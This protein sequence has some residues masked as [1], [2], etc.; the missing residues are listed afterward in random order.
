MNV[1]EGIVYVRLSNGPYHASAANQKI[2][3]LLKCTK[4]SINNSFYYKTAKGNPANGQNIALR[5]ASKCSVKEFEDYL[6][7][8]SYPELKDVASI[9][10]LT[11]ILTS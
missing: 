5:E 8:Q 11:P 2:G 4:S 3:A 9:Q 10:P 1:K 6:I 7:A